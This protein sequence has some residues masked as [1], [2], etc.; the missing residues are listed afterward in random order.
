MTPMPPPLRTGLGAYTCTCL[1]MT[2]QMFMN[3]N[4]SN[5]EYRFFSLKEPFLLHV[6][7]E[8][9]LEYILVHVRTIFRFMNTAKLENVN[10]YHE[11]ILPVLS[12]K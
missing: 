3:L 4:V 5:P 10:L 9:F 8:C 6:N 11:N 1:Y 2:V 7:N 12:P